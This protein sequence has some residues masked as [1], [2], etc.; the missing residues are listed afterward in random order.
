[1]NETVFDIDFTRALPPTLKN[2]ENMLALAKVVAG[3]LQTTAL[4]SRLNLI[5]ARIDE[6]EENVLDILAY[7]FHVD[8][9]SYDYPIAAKRAVIK[10][11]VRVH[12][13]L[14]TLYAVTTALGSVYPESEVEEW[15]DYNGEPFSFRVVLDV[16]NS[17]AP[18]EYFAI[19]KAV[20]SYKRLTAHMDD[21]IY[22][23]RAVVEIRVETEIFYLCAS[24]TGKHRSGTYPQ[25]N[26]KGG[27]AGGSI[28]VRPE[29]GGFAF[30]SVQAGTEPYRSTVAALRETTIQAEDGG[31]G[32]HYRTGATGQYEAGT[33]PQRNTR[34]G[35]GSAGVETYAEGRGY[36]FTS[37]PAGAE[38]YR[39]TTA[40]LVSADIEADAQGGGFA[41]SSIQAGTEPGRSTVP[42]FRE[43]VIQAE[44]DGRGFR[45]R[46]GATG[47]YNAGTE[48]QDGT[49]AGLE[50]GGIIPSV[51]AEGFTFRVKRCGTSRCKNDKKG[52]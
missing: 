35:A 42:V 17:K 36:A 29:G 26:M 45:Y 51:T 34:G 14:G 7:D 32:F 5:Y 18:A 24:M 16:T 15:F 39:N 30:S 49:A 3:E 23:C 47:Q 12:K 19:K 37:P 9:Y 20:E 10:D 40:E 52:V 46:T 25:R 38:P 11:S 33:E 6:L 50:S 1:M 8:W 2:D 44:D 21:L 28:T 48:P 43:S 22:Q 31:A 13:R 4:L 41:F 27:I